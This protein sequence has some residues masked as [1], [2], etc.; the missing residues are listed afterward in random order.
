MR[1]RAERRPPG[2]RSRVLAVAAILL[3]GCG[4]SAPRPAP[5]GW[6][7]EPA[8]G[9]G[10]AADVVTVALLETV[11][12]GNAPRPANDSE[13]VVFRHLYEGLTDLDCRGEAAPA[14]ADSF[15]S[16]DGGRT[17]TFRLRE[18]A[19]FGDGEPVDAASVL[20]AWRKSRRTARADP[21]RFALWRD[22]KLRDVSADGPDLTVRLAAADADLPRLLAAPEFAVSKGVR[23]D[24][25]LGTRGR[26]LHGRAGDARTRWIADGPEG[27][28]RFVVSP[29]ADPRD[30]F[31]SGIDVL[32]TRRRAAL[33]HLAGLADANLTT[34]PWSRLYVVSTTSAWGDD[35]P[36]GVRHELAEQVLASTARVAEGAML[37]PVDES[38]GVRPATA[39]PP[40]SGPS[41]RMLLA[42]AGDPDA[43]ALAERI[44]SRWARDAAPVTVVPRP[45]ADVARAMADGGGPGV[46]A[47]A[48]ELAAAEHQRRRRDALAPAGA[49]LPGSLVCTRATLVTRA[50]ITGVTWG[51]DGVPR[52]GGVR[53][54]GDATP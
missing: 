23:D 48:R 26:V 49:A 18:G 46:L 19:R 42:P 25:P 4:G 9:G 43:V 54:D 30:A 53:R 12:P 51:Y 2:G 24:W 27:E 10:R 37:D 5:P 6:C 7:P 36:E 14:L 8:P 52:L 39:P 47:L 33:Q 44:A 29:G 20:R 1:T 11:D 28:V 17:W 34:L 45:A 15:G 22:L 35:P 50:G 38:P 13:A 21:A 40:P 16:G 32:V 3:A 41:P 31:L